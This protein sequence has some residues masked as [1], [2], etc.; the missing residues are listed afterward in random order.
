MKSLFSKLH[1]LPAC[2]MFILRSLSWYR[3]NYWGSLFMMSVKPFVRFHKKS[4]SPAD[5]RSIPLHELSKHFFPPGHLTHAKKFSPP[6][7]SQSS[8]MLIFSSSDVK[9][10]LHCR[11]DNAGEYW[12]K[13][14]TKIPKNKSRCF[15]ES[16]LQPFLVHCYSDLPLV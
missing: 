6:I 4:P 11:N 12:T 16:A 10:A 1:W 9:A 3:Q 14:S 13:Q 2:P 5:S 7:Y 15:G 8:T